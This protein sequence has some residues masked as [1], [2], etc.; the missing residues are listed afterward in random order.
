MC[1]HSILYQRRRVIPSQYSTETKAQA[2]AL[3]RQGV[4]GSHAAQQLGIPERTV[5]FWALRLRQIASNETDRDLLDDDYRLALR[6]GELLHDALDAI[7]DA[8]TAE[9]H[10]SQLAITRGISLSKIAESKTQ[11]RPQ[12]G[13]Y[14]VVLNAAQPLTIEGEAR[15]V[16]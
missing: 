5:N 4:P 10:L 3:V 15:E 12:S 6:T 11:G 7:H 2:M 16:P 13:V 1:M 9:K 14:V 8:G